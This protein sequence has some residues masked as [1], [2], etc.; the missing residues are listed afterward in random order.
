MGT[1][2]VQASMS[3]D[4]YIADPSD[5]VGALFDWYGDGDV[6]FHRR[7][8]G[9]GLPRVRGERGLPAL[10]MGEHRAGGVWPPSFDLTNGGRAARR[11]AKPC[12]W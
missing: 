8:S 12:P 11:S 9:S 2:V 6:E 1:V 7:G 5:Q 3:L 4:G 10:G